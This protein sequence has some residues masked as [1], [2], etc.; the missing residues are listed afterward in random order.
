MSS[1]KRFEIDAILGEE[2]I[3]LIDSLEVKDEFEKGVYH[4]VICGYKVDYKNVLIVFPLSQDE[5]GFVCK[6]P[7]CVVNYKSSESK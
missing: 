1:D 7:G 5:V 4:C 6:K 3:K 2:F